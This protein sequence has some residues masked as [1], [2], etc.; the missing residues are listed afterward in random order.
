MRRRMEFALG[1]S[2]GANRGFGMG[3]LDQGEEVEGDRGRGGEE[4]AGGGPHV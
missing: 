1:R 2:A 4:E 3:V